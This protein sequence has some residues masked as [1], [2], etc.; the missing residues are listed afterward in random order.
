[1]ANPMLTETLAM[2]AAIR[3]LKL[4][5]AYQTRLTS[6]GAEIAQHMKP[7]ILITFAAAQDFANE[8]AEAEA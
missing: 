5:G 1:M 7:T 3:A 6:E 8:I 2:H 4:K